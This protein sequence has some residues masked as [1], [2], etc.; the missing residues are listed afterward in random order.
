MTG[1][2]QHLAWLPGIGPAGVGD[3][4]DATLGQGGDQ[5]TD[6]H[7]HAASVALAGLEQG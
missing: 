4:L 1:L 7:V 6:V 2:D 5:L 3:A